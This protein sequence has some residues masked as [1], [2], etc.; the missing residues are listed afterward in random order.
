MNKIAKKLLKLV[1]AI[2]LIITLCGINI[3]FLGERIISYA[4]SSL[5]ETNTQNVL[6]STY[7]VDENGNRKST[8]NKY[9]SDENIKLCMEVEVLNEGYFNGQIQLK[10]SN[11]RVKQSNKNE[12]IKSINDNVIE[13]NQ[14]NAGKNVK[15]ELEVEPIKDD[16]YNL[17]LLKATTAVEITGTYVTESNNKKVQAERNV[18]LILENPYSLENQENDVNLSAE[19]VTNRVYEINGE[20]KRLVQVQIKSGLNGNKFPIKSKDIEVNV[21]D[22]TQDIQIQNRGTYNTNNNEASPEGAWDKQQNKYKVNIKNIDNEGNVNWNKVD[23]DNIIISYLL[24]KDTQ[25][26]NGKLLINSKIELYDEQNTVLNVSREVEIPTEEIDGALTYNILGT[27]ELYKGNLYYGEQTGFSTQS[28]LDVRYKNIA[29]NITIQ[30]G[31]AVYESDSDKLDANVQYVKS[32]I[33]KQDIINI[34]GDTG[35]LEIKTPSGV[36]LSS[37]TKES[38]K[39]SEEEKITIEYEPQNSLIFN[40]S[41][42]ENEG[43]IKIENEEVL[44]GGEYS[45]KEVKSFNKLSIQANVDSNKNID[46]KNVSKQIELK[47]P[48]TYAT[49][50]SNKTTLSTLE[51]N[52]NVQLNV[53]LKTD[54]VKFDLYKN[55]TVKIEFPNEVTDVTGQINS[56]NIDGFEIVSG[57]INTNSNGNK[58]IEIKLLGE[59][60]KHSNN[61]S[62]GL[63][64]N[65][66]ANVVVDKFTSTKSSEIILKY[67]NE[68]DSN[69]VHE[70][71]LPIMLKSKDGLFIDNT[72]SNFNNN[73]DVL[74][75][76]NFDKLTGTLDINSEEKNLES[77]MVMINNYESSIKNVEIVGKL[78]EENTINSKFENQIS[79]EGVN[80]NISY[81]NDENNWSEDINSVENAKFY[82][83]KVNEIP[84]H[85]IAKIKFNLRIDAELFYN[86]TL[87][88]EQYVSYAYGEDKKSETL[89]TELN[90]EKFAFSNYAFDKVTTP[91]NEVTGNIDVSTKTILVN[92]ILKEGD[93][94][95]EGSTLKNVITIANKTGQDLK[96]VKVSVEQNNAVIYDLVGEERINYAISEDVVIEHLYKEWDNGNKT[97]DTIDNLASG[98]VINLYYEVVVNEVEGDNQTTYGN[99]NVSADGIQP[100]ALRTISN[101]IEQ[102]EVKVINSCLLTE[103]TEIG[104]NGGTVGSKIQIKNLAKSKLNNL[105]GE[106]KL[107]DNLYVVQ[108]DNK[109]DNKDDDKKDDNND[110]DEYDDIIIDDDIEDDGSEDSGDEDF[111]ETEDDSTVDNPNGYVNL[112]DRNDIINFF[113]K[114][115]ELI[116]DSVENIEYDSTNN[117]IKFKIKELNDDEIYAVISPVT[118]KMDLSKKEDYVYINTKITSEAGKTYYSNVEQRKILQTELDISFEQIADVKE[119]QLLKNGDTFNITI[120]IRNKS[121]ETTLISVED[122]IN[123][124]LIINSVKLINKT[125]QKDITDKIIEGTNVLSFNYTLNS[126]SEISI[127][128]NVTLETEKIDVEATKITN[129]VKIIYGS[130]YLY[131]DLLTLKINNKQN[132]DNKDD[133]SPEPNPN[134][135]NNNP[136]SDNTSKHRIS[137][138][139]WLDSNEDGIKNENERKMEG[140]NVALYDLSSNSFVKNEKGELMQKS[141][142]SAGQYSFT[143]KDGK[144]LVVFLYDSS[145]YDITLYQATGVNEKVNN[146]A[147]A[148]N[149]TI[150]G[151]ESIIGVTDTI[152]IQKGNAENID[153]G[154]IQKKKF[155]MKLDK[156]V[157][158]L[159]I[160]NQKGK[161]T[162]TYDN[163]KLAKAEIKAKYFNGSK[164]EV[165]YKIVVTNEGDV[166]GFVGDIVDYIPSG[167]EF[168]SDLN[169]DWYKGIDGE[170][171]TTK[172]QNEVI[173]PGETKEIYLVLT[174][175]LTEKSGGLI[176]NTAEIYSSSNTLNI[177]DIDS[178]ANNRVN[179]EDDMSDASIIISI[180]TGV[181]KI[182]LSIIVILLIIS[183][184]V[185]IILRRKEE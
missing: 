184:G 1:T 141:T 105:T 119:D 72:V 146:D 129:Q 33:A 20:S 122:F 68:N 132:D 97:F 39:D 157:S 60:T 163:E 115:N 40:I 169:K 142:D 3:L 82:K 110:D 126:K 181:V 69:E 35:K 84:S 117:T 108:Q 170:I 167:F 165:E 121:D 116:N 61:I 111:N 103:E 148:K 143:V 32:T 161:T 8:V 160:E 174:K 140:I 17:N 175:V 137:G 2:M 112:K 128:I 134:P 57:N 58:E 172:F 13:L 98:E 130:N 166:D 70:E 75:T 73:G 43:Y 45:K 85:G 49:L 19:I 93:N 91:T 86:E 113:N 107:S 66:N 31:N 176:T 155:D 164:V 34:L 74:D 94:V 96:N 25:I 41:N 154:F 183:G 179:G 50:N 71:K 47:E 83:V 48:E 26:E 55:P 63:I 100:V 123:K 30:E 109:D 51:T 139:A 171:H 106:I 81:S 77:Q 36:T 4:I 152:D 12:Y 10:N 150:D 162:K 173:K 37:L 168:K 27:E 147:I 56:A 118:T 42:S 89:E 28:I 88:I 131:S 24:D 80:A 54:D 95:Y 62:E 124:G 153:I 149:V 104:S 64:L 135:D 78:N 133:P 101:N 127:V 65:I 144:Y 79:V 21:I 14:I 178:T 145:I 136:D 23:N 6:F 67:T 99:V 156:Y 182:T 151:N 15:L 44:N 11:F 138:V 53:V 114:N 159:S 180:G 125:E 22:G 29:D 46:S 16:K 9:M 87:K 5:E 52:E 177:S 59:Q 76:I 102:A 92:D 18:Q 158:K 90:T 120:N 38:I 185:I 7:F